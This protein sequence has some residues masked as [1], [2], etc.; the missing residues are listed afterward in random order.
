[1][2]AAVAA[3]QA[4]LV[5]E[6]DGILA[7]VTAPERD[8]AVAILDAL[9]LKLDRLQ[10][11]VTAQDADVTAARC[12]A[13]LADVATLEILQAPGLPYLL[14]AQY[15]ARPRLV[16][17]AT[18]ELTVARGGGDTFAALGDG[19]GPQAQGRLRLELDGYNAPLT[20]GNFAALVSKG[21]FD[22][23]PLSGAQKDETLFALP[24]APPPLARTLP[25]ELRA[26]GEYE[27]RYR[28]PL[29]VLGS[30]E[31]PVLPLSV[32][33][34]VAMARGPEGNDSDGGQFFIYRF[35]RAT[36]GLGGAAFEEG[37]YAVFGYITEGTELLKQ[38]RSGDRIVSARLG[39]GA[40]RL[41]TPP[42][43]P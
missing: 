36:A 9:T 1:M 29:D 14:P 26:E 7:A 33:G 2:A 43:A 13:S 8:A 24:T 30:G 32:F 4:S 15:A 19:A 38:L 28:A 35:A 18:V 34:S 40:E 20:A 17:R 21:Y 42:A 3:C 31:L 27:P 41:V 11:A 6:R 39:A 16:G 22:G 25:L 37:N 10:Q 5:A 12:A 23:A